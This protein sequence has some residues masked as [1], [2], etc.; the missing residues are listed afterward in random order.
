MITLTEDELTEFLDEFRNSWIRMQTGDVVRGL[1]VP[2]E[3]IAL[4]SLLE[5]WVADDELTMAATLTSI[6][7]DDALA[8]APHAIVDS[9]RTASL[10]RPDVPADEVAYCVVSPVVQR[11]RHGGVPWRRWWDVH[12]LHSLLIELWTARRLAVAPLDIVRRELRAVWRVP[13]EDVPTMLTN[14]VNPFSLLPPDLFE[15]SL[16]GEATQL[17]RGLIA[18]GKLQLGVEDDLH[19]YLPDLGDRDDLKEVVRR[20]RMR[21]ELEHAVSSHVRGIGPREAERLQADLASWDEQLGRFLPALTAYE[22][23]LCCKPR[24]GTPYRDQCLAAGRNYWVRPL[25]EE[26]ALP[27]Q[28][29]PDEPP[30]PAPP[31]MQDE[32]IGGGARTFRTN[33]GPYPVWLLTAET[34]LSQTA[35]EALRLPGQSYGLGH[36]V[37]ANRVEIRLRLP[38]P[39]GDPGPAR[40]VPFFYSLDYVNSA[41]QLLHLAAVGHVRLVILTLTADGPCWREEAS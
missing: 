31:W 16:T 1:L 18:M 4:Y 36:R 14:A 41:W 33:V 5:R 2:G 17:L 9:L 6:A 12:G 30:E 37:D 22:V 13:D 38:V 40:E 39:D 35:I 25:L 10:V 23:E 21:H 26:D 15:T 20:V 28:I 34:S 8:R 27:A 3:D 24:P 32:I 19:G 11:V 7:S 29:E